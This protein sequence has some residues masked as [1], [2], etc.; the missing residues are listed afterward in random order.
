MSTVLRKRYKR[1][2][3]KLYKIKDIV[4]LPIH[5]QKHKPARNFTQSISNYTKEGREEIHDTLKAVDRE[6]LRHVQRF[7]MK[8]RTVEYNDNRIAKFIAQYG[9][10]AI[11]K[12]E[13]GLV[14]WHCHHKIPLEFGGQDNYEN[15]VIVLE[16]IHLAIHS[17]DSDKA[18]SILN[19]Y[20]IIEDK[21][22]M[23]DKLRI[24]A[25]RH[26]IFSSIQKLVN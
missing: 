14:G 8:H 26:P 13:V 15:L 10:C 22:V 17:D 5:A 9:K 19:K 1:Y 4:L 12:Q 2:N 7:Y 21:K 24:S 16:D 23:F 20:D 11:T 25:R 3:P 6:T 18:K